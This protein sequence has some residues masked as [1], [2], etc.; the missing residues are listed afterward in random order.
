MRILA[1]AAPLYSG[2]LTGIGYYTES[3]LD[4]LRADDKVDVSGYAFNFLGKKPSVSGPGIHEQKLLPG[5]LLNYP[6]Y[7]G[8]E[9]PLEMFFNTRGF[10]AILG[11][12]YLIPPTLRHIPSIA[13]IHDLCFYDH[14]EWVQGPNA[15]IL[16]KLLPKTVKRSAGII[17]I[18]EFSLSR[19]REVYNYTGPALV[20]SIPPKVSMA[21]AK[22]P[23]QI[24]LEPKSYFLIVGTI[25]PRK[26]LGLALDA[27]E[28]LPKDLQREYP[29]VLAGKPGWDPRILGRLRSGTNKNIYYLDYVSESERTWL[30]KNATATLV[31]SHYEG[32]GMMTLESL[33]LGTPTI[34]SDIPPQREILGSYGQYFS[35]TDPTAL[36][37]LMEK[38]SSKS[39]VLE[40]LQKQSK[41][42][43]K[44]SWEQVIKQTVDFIEQV[45]N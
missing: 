8:V 14:P 3:L 15:H 22:K 7:L 23:M 17:S 13:T 38:F 24:S 26:N 30:Y 6:R 16:R 4:G 2:P 18:S 29:L 31:P 21:T 27:Y 19:I 5:K 32:F 12:N 41:V 43:E 44:Y 20:V 28:K 35:P 45:I 1:D 36:T 34:T 40:A 42:L 10:D 25:E 39:Y 9:L 33:A 37:E 11:T